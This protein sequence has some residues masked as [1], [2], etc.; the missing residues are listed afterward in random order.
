MFELPSNIPSGLN[1]FQTAQKAKEQA[2]TDQHEK[3]LT[4][5]KEALHQAQH[6]HADAIFMRHYTECALESL[7][8]LGRHQEVIEYCIEARKHYD[9]HPPES[10]MAKFDY[11]SIIE[12][13]AINQAKANDNKSALALCQQAINLAA[14]LNTSMPMAEKLCQWLCRG[15]HVSAQRLVSEQKRGGYFSVYRQQQMQNNT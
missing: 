15:L 12:R 3:A 8:L 6:V 5:Y 2:W 1:H 13:Q 9:A 11:A 7:E 14:D 4:L 10:D